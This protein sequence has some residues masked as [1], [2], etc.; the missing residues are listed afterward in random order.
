MPYKNRVTAVT[1]IQ[2]L[3]KELQRMSIIDYDTLGLP[4]NKT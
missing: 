4:K 3:L 2:T 1:P